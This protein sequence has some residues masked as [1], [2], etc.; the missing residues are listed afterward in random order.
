MFP[1]NWFDKNLQFDEMTL[2]KFMD[3]FTKQMIPS[4]L[5][6]MLTEANQKQSTGERETKE[7]LNE[8]IFE[9]HDYIYIR[10]P[11]PDAKSLKKVKIRYS[12]N[13]CSISGL[14]DDNKVYEMILPKPVQKKGAK[15]VY[16]EQILEIQLPKSIDWY[17]SE[18]EID[19]L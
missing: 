5:Q 8:N 12:H 6:S 16:R 18:I 1:W 7:T 19:E 2:Q 4:Y 17:M 14:L 11:I 15:A 9:T 3:Q 13:K 10:I